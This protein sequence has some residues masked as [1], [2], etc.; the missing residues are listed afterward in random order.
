M[1]REIENTQSFNELW[2][3]P[4]N[5][6]I[7]DVVNEYEFSP[8]VFVSI[9]EEAIVYKANELIGVDKYTG[10]TIWKEDVRSPH[11]ISNDA[12]KIYLINQD[13]DPSLTTSKRCDQ[14]L[15]ICEAINITAFDAD[16]GE[17]LWANSY[18][19]IFHVNRFS[20]SD[21][22]A[23]LLGI[24]SHGAY[25]SEFSI[26]TDSGKE[27]FFQQD[28]AN[29][30][31][32]SQPGIRFNKSLMEKRLGREQYDIINA[33]STDA[34]SVFLTKS[35]SSLWAIENNSYEVIGKVEFTGG[36]FVF[37]DINK[38]DLDVED[39]VVVVYLGDSG[40]LF[41]FDFNPPE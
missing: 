37:G 39:N 38:F 12:S 29:F 28:T 11:Q 8:N 35:D 5:L 1:L 10:G 4:V 15:P 30:S 40:Q 7:I 2:S 18:A 24:G 20:L 19:N 34:Y 13:N 16:S 14:N 21:N 3:M 33:V 26:Y 23:N 9:Y 22:R 32:S 41:V 36:P 27:V 31:S 6:Q 17:L 25:I